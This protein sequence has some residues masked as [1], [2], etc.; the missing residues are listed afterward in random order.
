M[1]NFPL[2]EKVLSR[3]GCELH[4]WLAG[5]KNLPLMVMTH[6]AWINHLEFEPQLADFSRYYRLLL[7][8]VRG[9]GLSRPADPDFSVK[10]AVQDLLALLYSQKEESAIL[11]GHS[12]GGNLSQEVVFYHPERVR[13]LVCIDCTCNTLRLNPVETFMVRMARPIF[14]AYPLN[15]LRSQSANIVSDQPAVRQKLYDL[16]E[17]LTKDE[18][19]NV[20]TELTACLHYEP[21]YQIKKPLLIIVGDLDKTGNIR[22]VAPIWAE[23]DKGSELVIIPNAG[24][25]VN[26]DQPELVNQ[27]V[28]SFLKKSLK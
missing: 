9:H 19:V 27:H 13:A 6:G 16:L 26:L 8:D 22:K 3:N 12:M 15:A 24:H 11:L 5:P 18:Y 7:W 23:R 21:N 1:N 25:A 28:L 4:Y 17:G 10:E 2:E 14:K 20:M